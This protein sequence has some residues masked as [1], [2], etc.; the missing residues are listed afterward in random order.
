MLKK[1]LLLTIAVCVLS[2][3][4][5]AIDKSDY[6][7]GGVFDEH[8]YN[9]ALALEKVDSA[10]LDLFVGDYWDYDADGKLFFNMEAF[11]ADYA[12]ALAAAAPKVN[13]EDPPD[14][15]IADPVYPIGSYVDES[16]NVYSPDGELLSPG[17]TPAVPSDTLDEIQDLLPSDAVM[18]LEMVEPA[19]PAVYTV[20]DLRRG[21]DSSA[22]ALAGLKALI[23]SIFGEYA[24]V[25]TTTAVTETV[26]NVTTTT[27][28]DTVASGAA[29][30]DYAWLSGV[31]LFGILLYCVM[32]IFGSILK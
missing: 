30:V 27:L 16:G 7:I 26:D 1:I 32:R 15:P 5:F 19:D 22:G 23:V 25:T 13:K 24:P 28:I 4:A 9:A 18:E 29:G 31:A 20:S 2:V 10:G 17:T 21:I 6:M 14:D 3:P 11:E 12:A 8:G